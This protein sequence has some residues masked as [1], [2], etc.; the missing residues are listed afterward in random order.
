MHASDQLLHAIDLAGAPVCVGLDPVLERLPR[1]LQPGEPPVARIEAFCARIIEAVSGVAPAVKPQS[2]CFERYGH[3]GVAAL[4]RIIAMAH[5]A[6]L[7][8]ILDAKRGDIGVSAEHYAS[9]AF[10]PPAPA[11]WI[12]VN[13]Y[14]GADGI[15][16]FL[17][18]GHGAFALVR[19]SNPG[20]DALQ[21]LKLA[22]GR[23]VAAAVADLVAEIG[24]SHMGDGGYSDLGAVV[25]ATKG[26]DIALLRQRMPHTIFLVPGYGAQGGSLNDILASF[27]PDRRG[28]LINASRS[29]IYAFEPDDPSWIDAVRNAAVEMKGE[30]GRGLG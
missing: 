5:S 24:A 10:A 15:T 14:L 27:N 2:A 6:G 11:H 25:G 12:T 23:T 20:G 17:R 19:T 8:V 18:D 4:E 3:D 1:S 28:A 13:S 30:L 16:P 21:N 22:D 9:A 7:V 29:I 26:A